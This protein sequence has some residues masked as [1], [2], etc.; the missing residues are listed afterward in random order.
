MDYMLLVNTLPSILPD[1]A[2]ASD[3]FHCCFVCYGNAHGL[4]MVVGRNSSMHGPNLV[5]LRYFDSGWS[6]R[7]IFNEVMS[8]SSL[9]NVF[10]LIKQFKDT[11][12]WLPPASTAAQRTRALDRITLQLVDQ[13]L[14][15]DPTL[16]LKQIKNMLY[17]KHQVTVST[18]SICRS[19]HLS[20]DKGDLGLTLKKL[21]RGAD[22]CICFHSCTHACVRV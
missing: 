11:F 14:I 9:R 20:V 3:L 22:V 15:T 6:V 13:M 2:A 12:S 7:R 18:S 17:E 8:F 4:A 16:H 10:R 19:I 21:S 5:L 1:F